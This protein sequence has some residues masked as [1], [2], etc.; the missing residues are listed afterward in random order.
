MTLN[1]KGYDVQIDDEDWDK[2]K[3]YTWYVDMPYFIKKG[4]YKIQA[5]YYFPDKTHKTIILS[6]VIMGVA[7][8]DKDVIVDH[9]DGN[10]LDNR[11]QNLRVCN[12][13]QN[14]WNQKR[15][16][17]SKTGYKGVCYDKTC[18]KYRAYLTKHRK[19]CNLGYYVS[20]EEAAKAYDKGALLCYGEYARLNFD[21]ASY[22]EQDIQWAKEHLENNTSVLKNR[23]SKYCGV[24]RHYS[25]W[26]ARITVNRI[27]YELGTFN[28]EVEAAMVRDRKALELLGDGAKLNFPRETYIKEQQDGNIN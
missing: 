23:S 8:S 11:K 19:R 5:S 24:H 21:A 13:T 18:N 4:R 15:P 26:Q 20:P 25:K 28:T 16:K 9:I 27:S 6:R 22:T 14:C 1:I 3:G 10:T 2:V 17:N 12:N 7:F